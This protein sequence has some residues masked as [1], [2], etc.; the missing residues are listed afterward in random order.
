MSPDEVVAAATIGGVIVAGLFG[1][2]GFI[3]GLAGLHH[4]KQAKE[5]A[6]GANLIAKDANTIATGTNTL[7]TEANSIAR[8]AN[9]IARKASRTTF[10]LDSGSHIEGRETRL[11]HRRASDRHRGDRNP[12]GYHGRD[13]QRH[14]EPHPGFRST[15]CSSPS[16]QRHRKLRR[17]E[18]GSV[19]SDVGSGRPRRLRLDELPVPRRQQR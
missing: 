1:I 5:A 12:R 15:S 7:S 6:A 11:H 9:D 14:P 4:A 8:E 17:P 13:L 10:D 18:L 19:P 3:V 2:T 16:C